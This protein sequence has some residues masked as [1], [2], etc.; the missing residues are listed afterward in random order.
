[1]LRVI[2]FLYKEHRRWIERHHSERRRAVLGEMC[3]HK[4]SSDWASLH[5]KITV[6]TGV[7]NLSYMEMG[8]MI[9]YDEY[10]F[11]F[12]YELLPNWLFLYW[13]P[14]I[15][16]SQSSL[17][18]R[19]LNRGR[20]RKQKDTFPQLWPCCPLTPPPSAISASSWLFPKVDSSTT[21]TRIMI[22]TS[23]STKELM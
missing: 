16:G 2:V 10:I 11:L 3:G 4:S 12:S 22:R 18:T 20:P 13:T 6:P 14:A 9:G 17:T 23:W 21:W 19:N 8:K 7:C 5:F 15:L 1:M